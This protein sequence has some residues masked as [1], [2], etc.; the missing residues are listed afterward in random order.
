[1]SKPTKKAIKTMISNVFDK[2][3][4]A[5]KDA[6][7]IPVS[8]GDKFEFRLDN[9]NDLFVQRDETIKGKEVSWVDAVT[10]DGT[11]IS[12]TQLTRRNN[13]LPLTG[14][15]VDER[16]ESVTTLFDDK[17][18]LILKVVAIRQKSFLQD[19]G[20]TTTSNYYIFEILTGKKPEDEDEDEE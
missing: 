16:A 17:G 12:T 3:H 10:I 14:K 20:S 1:M 13:G 11:G 18:V 19:D 8:V 9:E 15:T 5:G 7:S 2:K 4:G 6:R